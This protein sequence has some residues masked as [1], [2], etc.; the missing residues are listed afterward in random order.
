MT[1][2]S[3]ASDQA[4]P[5]TTFDRSRREVVPSS[6][7]TR[8]IRPNGPAANDSGGRSMTRLARSA[9]DAEG[10]PLALRAPR[11]IEPWIQPEPGLEP[12]RRRRRA[13]APIVA[14]A[15]RAPGSSPQARGA[16]GRWPAPSVVDAIDGDGDRGRSPPGR[17]NAAIVTPTRSNS[18]G[19]MAGGRRARSG[20]S[21][22]PLTGGLSVRRGS[23]AGSAAGRPCARLSR[24][25][26]VSRRVVAKP[27]RFRHSPATVNAPQGAQVRSPTPR[28][29]LEP[30]RER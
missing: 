23:R 6:A 8:T 21:Q 11:P 12:K 10:Q 26:S 4:H 9:I 15:A 13:A 24:T 27:V 5:S 25:D 14:A 29:M 16:Q 7:P 30:S 2:D 3:V 1:S 19:G 22:A 28:C 20:W 17:S 18:S